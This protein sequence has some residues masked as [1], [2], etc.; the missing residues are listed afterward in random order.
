M[1]EHILEDDLK[2]AAIIAAFVYQAALRDE[3]LPRKSLPKT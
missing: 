1:Y 2:R 3:K